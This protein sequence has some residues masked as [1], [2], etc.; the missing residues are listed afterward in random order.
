MH[1][2]SKLLKLVMLLGMALPVNAQNTV[3]IRDVNLI[4]VQSATIQKNK[5]VL[6]E[7]GIIKSIADDLLATKVDLTI[8]GENKY[9]IP[10]L[11]NMYTH[12]NEDNL[13]LYLANG[14]TTIKDAPS[15]LTA[16]GLR[17][18]INNGELVGPRIFAVG[19]RATGMPA[20]YPSQQ[21]I[22]TAKEG[23]AQVQEAKRLGYDGMFIYGSCDKD[24]YQPIIE[25]AEKL[26]LHISGHYPQNVDMKIALNSTQR[27]FDNLTGITRRGKIRFD[28]EAFIDGLL[29]SNQAITPT[30]TVHRLWSQSDKKDSIYAAIPKEYIPNKMKANWLPVTNGSGSYPYEEVANLIKEMY[31]RGVPL[32]VGSDG[33]FPMVVNGFSYH[34]EIRNFSEIGISNDEILKMATIQSAEFLGYE[35][36]GLVKEGYLADLVLLD[37]NPLEDIKNLKRIDHV[38]VRGK[39]FG[40]E[41]IQAQ[42]DRLKERLKSNTNRFRKWQSVIVSWEQENVTSYRHINNQIVVGE[43]KIY[44]QKEDKRN[45]NLTAINVMDGPD[46]RESLMYTR[47]RNRKVDSLYVKSITPEGIYEATISTNKTTAIIKGTAPFHG[48]FEFEEPLESGTLLLGPFT[49]RYFEMDMAANY[50]LAMLLKRSLKA[51]QA[52]QLPVIQIELNSEEYGKKLIVDNSEY[53]ILKMNDSNFKIIYKGMSGHRTITTPSNV[54]DVVTDDKN[55][56]IEIKQN[57]KSINKI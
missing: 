26:N 21:P 57:N 24:T 19:L 7:D 22:R 4:D 23:I 50:I 11:I 20:P 27:S 8:K 56:V 46:F 5:D 25:E 51:N 44:V 47:I 35:N 54:I 43:E 53:T 14:Q 49:S 34:D 2:A 9:L 15:H 30:L 3:L 48:E 33:G 32:Y 18:R 13:W 38:I 39:A 40:N 16:L 12:V 6:I 31:E 41:Q 17:D 42:L 52:D 10:G 45:F 28:K 1:T 37:E 29:R 36:L 55:E